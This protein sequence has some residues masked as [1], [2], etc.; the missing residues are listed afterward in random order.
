MPRVGFEPAIPAFERVKTVQALDRAAIMIGSLLLLRR[1][2][3]LM[4]QDIHPHAHVFAIRNEFG[5][6]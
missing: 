3:G 4:D 1:E 5:T 6:N 2:N